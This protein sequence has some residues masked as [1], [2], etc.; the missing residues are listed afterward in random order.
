MNPMEDYPTPEA[1]RMH[2]EIVKGLRWIR[3]NPEALILALQQEDAS[4]L[5]TD[6]SE[7]GKVDPQVVELILQQQLKYL[8]RLD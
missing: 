4:A 2:R 8:I 3:T 5:L 6:L 7:Q 1:A